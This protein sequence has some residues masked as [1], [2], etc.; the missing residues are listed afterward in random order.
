[1]N[2]TDRIASMPNSKALAHA[3]GLLDL[4]QDHPPAEQVLASAIMLLLWCQRYNIDPRDVLTTSARRI[5][6]ALDEQGPGNQKHVYAIKH[7]MK[8]DVRDAFSY[9]F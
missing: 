9:L 4:T 8:A 2:I 7:F 1:M 3:F 5:K 6:D